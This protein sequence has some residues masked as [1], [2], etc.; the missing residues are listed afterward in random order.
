ML[1]VLLFK[2]WSLSACEGIE[3][4][5]HTLVQFMMVCF[6]IPKGKEMNRK[7]LYAYTV[8]GIFNTCLVRICHGYFFC[9]G[10]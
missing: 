8:G 1:F 7:S 2:V 3:T 10:M 6:D 9:N 5:S 4:H